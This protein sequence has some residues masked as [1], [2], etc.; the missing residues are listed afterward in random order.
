MTKIKGTKKWIV[1]LCLMLSTLAPNYA[2]V[3]RSTILP[4]VLGN[5]NQMELYSLILIAG[6]LAMTLVL[7]IA[8]KIGD[9][10]GRKRLLI[11]NNVI[12][13]LACVV[14]AAAQ[15]AYIFAVGVFLGGVAYGFTQASVKASFPDVC[16][17]EEC[18][19][20]VG[21]AQMTDNIASLIA[22]ILGGIFADTI[23]WQ[24]VYII[25]IPCML[26]A[27][28]ILATSMPA[29]KPEISS[30]DVSEGSGKLNIDGKGMAAFILA[31]FPFLF[32]LSTTGAM[33]KAFSPIFWILIV[34]AVV[35]FIWMVYVET[36][37][38]NPMLPLFMFKNRDFTRVFLVSLIGFIGY[39]QMFYFPVYLQNVVG[40][41]ATISG[42]LQLPMGIIGIV[43]AGIFG[44]VIGR[45]G[46]YK[47][48][49]MIEMIALG[50]SFTMFAIFNA[51]TTAI[52]FIIAASFYGVGYSG[53]LVCSLC[54]A[55]ADVPHKDVGSATSLMLFTS[56][57]GVA[58]GNAL[59]GPIV[60][61]RWSRAAQVIP[62]EL[63][64]MLTPGQYS[65]LLNQ[66][67]LKSH[68]TIE[69][70]RSGLSE[71]F[72]PIFDQTVLD[73]RNQLNS[74]IRILSILCLILV[75]V[76]FFIL[77]TM[78]EKKRAGND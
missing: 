63:K 52:M 55:Q 72:R 24:W 21:I 70:I 15:N 71:E 7:P 32:L 66:A 17:E 76:G 41:S 12:F 73:L 5:F 19:R 48:L 35:G 58:F 42:Y 13:I 78:K 20:V 36:H 74:G 57:F 25:C 75:V 22:P 29:V 6:T 61:G 64:Q 34:I 53:I 65:D 69:A 3:A 30:G 39:A 67:T 77:I 59:G 14:I 40:F 45:R 62:D 56:S 68:E 10:V 50:I 1:I 49:L 31:I 44:V 33:I 51:E 18:P 37:V 4:T 46:R 11:I 8:G 38:K 60:N 2:A 47:L 27:T 26:F 28:I 43:V 9:M 54:Y 23:G 16:T